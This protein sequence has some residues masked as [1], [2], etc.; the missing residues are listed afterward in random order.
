[1]GVLRGTLGD[2]GSESAVLLPELGLVCSYQVINKN[3]VGS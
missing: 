2:E 3:E 1:M